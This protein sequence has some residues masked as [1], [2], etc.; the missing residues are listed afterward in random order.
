MSTLHAIQVRDCVT[1]AEHQLSC[2][3]YE[4]ILSCRK[5]TS[6]HRQ[7]VFA[8]LGGQGYQIHKTF[9]RNTYLATG[10]GKPDLSIVVKPDGVDSVNGRELWR[11]TGLLRSSGPIILTPAEAELLQVSIKRH[12]FRGKNAAQ[13]LARISPYL[14][15]GVL[16]DVRHKRLALDS[17]YVFQS[18]LEDYDA[19]IAQERLVRNLRYRLTQ[20]VALGTKFDSAFEIDSARH[21][22]ARGGLLERRQVMETAA[23]TL[24]VADAPP[25]AT[26]T[27]VS[28]AIRPFMEALKTLVDTE[29]T[30]LGYGTNVHDV[31]WQGYQDAMNVVGE[32]AVYVQKAADDLKSDDSQRQFD[33][34]FYTEPDETAKNACRWLI[35]ELMDDIACS[36]FDQRLQL[37]TAVEAM[38]PPD[39]DRDSWS[40]PSDDEED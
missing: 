4:G 31:Y 6:Q 11:S 29:I 7:E 9:D 21:A 38:F 24:S 32:L 5:T 10:D 27:S 36:T 19:L 1:G 3:C 22:A 2:R 16:T 15:V 8:E 34:D 12:L 14:A 20:P 18:R 25:F 39:Q 17:I 23:Q 40:Y 26:I 37:Q 28:S 33:Y 13:K 35:R 30:A